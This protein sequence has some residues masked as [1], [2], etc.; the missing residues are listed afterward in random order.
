MKRFM[1]VTAIAAIAFV[2]G[3]KNDTSTPSTT[4]SDV[5]IGT[6]VSEGTDVSP[7]LVAVS[8]TVKVL[9][10]FNDNGTYTI[11][12]IDSSDLATTVTGTFVTAAGGAAAPLDNIRTLVCTQTSPALTWSG[13][14]Q[15]TQG[16]PV[17][18]KYEVFQ[19][20]PPVTGYSAPTPSGGFGS[21]LQGTTPLGTYN[22]QMFKKQ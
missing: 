9:A 2:G 10:I 17:S 3:C 11:M 12:S 20:D 5:I 6:W 16:L 7:L 19:T 8:K 15:V 18:M 14:Y 4:T 22:T 1:L 21:T 13:I